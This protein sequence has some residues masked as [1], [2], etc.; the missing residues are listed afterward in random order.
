MIWEILVCDFPP[1]VSP[2]W[3]FFKPHLPL[4]DVDLLPD[5]SPRKRWRRPAS[6]PDLG[7]LGPT[8]RKFRE[9]AL[10]VFLKAAQL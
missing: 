2:D 7:I 9:E 10:G 4:P 6:V 8:N 5:G 3:D 1:P